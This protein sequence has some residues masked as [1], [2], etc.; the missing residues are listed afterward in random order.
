PRRVRR[1]TG[2]ESAAA[3]SGQWVGRACMRWP[4][5]QLTGQRARP[6]LSARKRAVPAPAVP[7]VPVGPA[8]LRSGLD[9]GRHRQSGT[10][11]WGGAGDDVTSGQYRREEDGQ[12]RSGYTWHLQYPLVNRTPV[13]PWLF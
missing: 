12:Q 4:A 2:E 10:G 11:R 13:R 6:R 7:P 5:A 1:F 3:V 9:G 8:A